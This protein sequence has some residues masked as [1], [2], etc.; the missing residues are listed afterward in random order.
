MGA[1]KDVSKREHISYVQGENNYS[2][3]TSSLRT[4]WKTFLYLFAGAVMIG[5]G[6]R[7]IFQGTFQPGS[8]YYPNTFDLFF[9]W[10]TLTVLGVIVL[11]LTLLTFFRTKSSENRHS[12]H[13]EENH[14]FNYP[15]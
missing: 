13:V 4:S 8:S 10:L 1:M 11:Y 2:L 6:L 14:R 15:T 9:D 12:K 7:M 5:H 3:F